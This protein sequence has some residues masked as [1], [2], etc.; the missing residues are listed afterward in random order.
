M[1]KH[2]TVDSNHISAIKK[3]SRNTNTLQSTLSKLQTTQCSYNKLKSLDLKTMNPGQIK[4]MYQ[5]KRDIKVLQDKISLL[6]DNVEEN[7]YYINAGK[8]LSEY[9]DHV[10]PVTRG[11]ANAGSVGGVG[12]GKVDPRRLVTRGPDTAVHTIGK[13]VLSVRNVFKRGECLKRY[14]NS[15]DPNYVYVEPVVNKDDICKTCNIE[16]VDIP[17]D[18]KLVCPKCGSEVT[19]IVIS[20]RPSY[21]ET[22]PDNTHF[23]YKKIGHFN[24]ALSNCQGKENTDIPAKVLDA[25][26]YELK[27]ER[28][29]S[30][31]KLTYDNIKRYLKKHK[32]TTYYKHIPLITQCLT[33][34]QPVTLDVDMEEDMRTMFRMVLSVWGVYK[35]KSRKNFMS[36][37]YIL[38]Q[39]SMI[40]KDEDL[41]YNVVIDLKMGINGSYYIGKNT[42]F[43]ILKEP[44]KRYE[45]DTS[46]RSICSHFGWPFYPTLGL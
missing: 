41:R 23:Q 10:N 28:I 46:W 2:T 45:Q 39:L 21:K 32:F 4:T 27:R 31:D 24:E 38:H 6:R 20:E 19:R 40:K 29:K 12:G 3:I 16:R 13:S 8:C 7:D 44:E 1:V 14:H 37:P 9:Y 35:P 34:I 33:G 11:K 25:I 17:N 22:P 26:N 42:I 15:T 36:Y 43:H 5:K 30:S 18:S